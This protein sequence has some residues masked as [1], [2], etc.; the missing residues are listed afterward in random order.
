MEMMMTIYLETT[1]KAAPA[2]G[3]AWPPQV[4]PG[5]GCDQGFSWCIACYVPLK[6]CL[7]PTPT[8]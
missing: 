6:L 3:G 1:V 5:W 8:C 4:P 2:E 7:P